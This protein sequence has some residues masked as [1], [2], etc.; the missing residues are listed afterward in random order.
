MA[1][2]LLV[3]KFRRRYGINDRKVAE[4]A[5][6]HVLHS[7]DVWGKLDFSF[8]RGNLPPGNEDNDEIHVPINL[9]TE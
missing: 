1:M 3:A 9:R 7:D 6:L 8:G 4:M 2:D 5:I